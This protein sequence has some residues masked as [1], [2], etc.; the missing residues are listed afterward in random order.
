M[1]SPLS[2]ASQHLEVTLLKVTDQHLRF[3]ALEFP[4]YEDD[5]R[6]SV[7]VNQMKLAFMFP[8][9][10]APENILD[11]GIQFRQEPPQDKKSALQEALNTIY[12][13]NDMYTIYVGRMDEVIENKEYLR[14]YVDGS[15]ECVGHKA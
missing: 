9:K 8:A 13:D 2:D 4:L 14:V 3:H 5:L 7:V 11:N 6:F 10:M 15:A 12:S 1:Y